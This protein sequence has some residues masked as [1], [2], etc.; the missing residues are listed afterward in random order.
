MALATL[1][2]TFVDATTVAWWSE[3]AL[4]SWLQPTA[5]AIRPVLKATPTAA[6]IA[7]IACS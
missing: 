4:W 5:P 3:A 1:P 6:L 7:R 2:H